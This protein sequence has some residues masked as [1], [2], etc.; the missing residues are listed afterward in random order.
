MCRVHSALNATY[1]AVAGGLEFTRI[2]GVEINKKYS[3]DFTRVTT[4]HY[5]IRFAT[6]VCEDAKANSKKDVI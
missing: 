6:A 5:S 4:I 3:D 1:T 2:M